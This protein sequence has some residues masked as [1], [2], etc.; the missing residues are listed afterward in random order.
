MSVWLTN[1]LA[2]RAWSEMTSGYRVWIY[3]VCRGQMDRD[4]GCVESLNRCVVLLVL[5][6]WWARFYCIETGG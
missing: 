4:D 5:C 1:A 2:R 6:C 3:A